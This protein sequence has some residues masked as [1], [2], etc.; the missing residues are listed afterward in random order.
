VL[1]DTIDFFCE[2]KTLKPEQIFGIESYDCTE[3]G[4]PVSQTYIRTISLKIQV[5]ALNPNWENPDHYII[6]K[7]EINHYFDIVDIE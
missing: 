1:T 3:V 5:Q 6:E 7:V 2:G 4:T